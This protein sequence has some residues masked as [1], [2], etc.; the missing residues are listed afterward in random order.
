[1]KLG[2]LTAA[3]P[4]LT[5]EEIARW[6]CGERL[7]DAGDRLLAGRRG[8]RAAVRA[9]VSHID[10]DNL[11]D[12]RARARSRRCSP[13]AGSRSPRSPTTRTRSTRSRPGARGR[14]A[15]PNGDRR[16]RSCSAS[17]SSAASP[18]RDQH[19][20][21]DENLETFAEVWPPIVR[22]RRASAGTRSRSRTAR[23]SCARQLARRQQ[24]RLLARRSGGGCSRSSRTTNFGLN[25][26]PSHLIWQFIDEVRADPRV[27]RPHLPRPRQGPG[28]RPRQA[29]RARRHGRRL[30]LGGPA[31]A[32]SG[33]GRLGRVL[34]ARST[35]SATTTSSSIEHEDRAFEGSVEAV[36]RGFLIARDNLRPY[37]R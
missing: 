5:L 28:D 9:G 1:M 17:K 16:R 36:Q 35:P 18:A 33:R 6:A 27:R 13:S 25:L 8:R 19:E 11:D 37:I 30:R 10:V 29:L 23:C 21:A 32:R 22:L 2:L 12:G 7:R 14:R 20:G 3:L 31:P 24:P 4:A 34:R 15:P 26:D